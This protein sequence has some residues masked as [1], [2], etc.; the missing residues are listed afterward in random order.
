MTVNRRQ[1]NEAALRAI[2]AAAQR[3]LAA[4]GLRPS[5]A[6]RMRALAEEGY[7]EAAEL[8]AHAAELDRAAAIMAGQ[9]D[10]TVSTGEHVRFVVGAWARARRT[11]QRVTGE[12]PL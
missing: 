10:P 11:W 4:G 9:G 5:L 3:V 1:A 6:A 2:T 7:P 8:L 12:P